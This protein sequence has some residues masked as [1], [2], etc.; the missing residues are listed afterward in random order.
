M[1]SR[2]QALEIYRPKDL[3]EKAFGDFKERLFMRRE[4][5]VSEENLDGKLFVQFVALIFMSYIKAAMNK[6]GL[7]KNRT[8]QEL[9]DE[10]DAKKRCQKTGKK[11]R[12]GE[13]TAIQKTLYAALA[14]EYP[15]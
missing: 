14:V 10:L 7:F 6:G 2:N 12:I 4:S 9:L 8:L 5:V 3:I 1:T 15:V 13:I 11:P